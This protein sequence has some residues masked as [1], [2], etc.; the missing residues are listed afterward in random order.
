M[1]NVNTLRKIIR[2]LP[3]GQITLPLSLR[4]RFHIRP[5]D[6][7]EV[8]SSGDFFILKPIKHDTSESFQH[9]RDA[10]WGRYRKELNKAFEKLVTLSPQKLPKLCR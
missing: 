8:I 4:E 2:V 7:M 9:E 5:D 3:K 1:N 10:T 6:V